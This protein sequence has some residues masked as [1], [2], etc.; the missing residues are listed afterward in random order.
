MSKEEARLD[1][2]PTEILDWTG[3]DGTNN[4]FRLVNATK[5]EAAWNTTLVMVLEVNAAVC[6]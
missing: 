3:R 6:Y 2:L 4:A 1:V 5:N